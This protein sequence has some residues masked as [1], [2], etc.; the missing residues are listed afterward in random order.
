M[1][2]VTLTKSPPERR[3]AS[4][5]L[6]PVG[7]AVLLGIQSLCLPGRTVSVDGKQR[8]LSGEP[9]RLHGEPLCVP[10]TAVCADGKTL[11]VNGDGQTLHVAGEARSVVAKMLCI[12][13]FLMIEEQMAVVTKAK[14]PAKDRSWTTY[15]CKQ[16]T[17][18]LKYGQKAVLHRPSGQPAQIFYDKPRLDENGNPVL[19][20][21]KQVYDA[22][23]RA[24]YHFGD[25]HRLDGPAVEFQDG[26]T[27]WFHS[28]SLYRVGGPAVERPDGYK[29]W[30]DMNVV[31]R[32]DGPAV[33]HPNGDEEWRINGTL[34]RVGGPAIHSSGHGGAP[35]HYYGGELH[36]DDG[37]AVVYNT[38]GKNYEELYYSHG[39][40]HR[41][42]G[43][44]II[45]RKDGVVVRE[46]W[47]FHDMRHRVGGPAVCE[48]TCSL[49]TDEN[50]LTYEGY[51]CDGRY[52]RDDGPAFIKY[53]LEGNITYQSWY[54]Y[55]HLHRED[56]PALI[57]PTKTKY[58]KMDKLHRIDGPA[59]VI[60]TTGLL[61]TRREE[62]FLHGKLHSLT[63]PARHQNNIPGYYIF[64]DRVRKD[65]PA[66]SLPP[67]PHRKR[68]AKEPSA[69]GPAKRRRTK[70]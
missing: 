4:A 25:L 59:K 60:V 40:Y 28:G 15:E 2:R 12:D 44:A 43:P 31:S 32:V 39:K 6:Q 47:R 3:S 57:T 33:I 21:G 66:L 61:G 48:Y 53:D 50:V 67:P 24:W 10:S 42:D 35:A 38:Y 29:A 54:F 41:V 30:C 51:Y 63:A 23:T 7:A 65:C 70:E 22:G 5:K 9:V 11:R 69:G 20:K 56:G 62:W 18:V 36:R 19:V 55:G 8:Y 13:V 17:V 27:K 49:T 14:L 37:P 26:E 52:H 34:H 45:E 68:P 1:S 64:G 16:W 46:E 58:Y